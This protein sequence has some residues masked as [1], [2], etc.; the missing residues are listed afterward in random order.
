MSSSARFLAVPG[1]H[2][3]GTDP[4]RILIVD[5]SIVAR[6]VLSR[7]LEACPEFVIAAS[8][9]TAAQAL[10][11]VG[12][13]PVD[14]ILL[15]LEMPGVGGLEALPQLIARSDGARVLV[16]SSM[17]A[18]GAAA[19][20]QALALGAADTLQKPGVAN[21]DGRFSD[22]LADRLIRIAA[23]RRHRMKP[24]PVVTRPAG[25]ATRAPIDC[26]AIGASTGG[27][28][29]LTELLRDFPAAFT[30]PIL[31]TQHLPAAFMPYFADQMRGIA[32][33]P[34]TVAR[35]GEKLVPGHILIAPGEGHI[36][37]KRIGHD[38][39]VMLDTTVS[40]TLC[41][42]SVDPMF[43][44]LAEVYGERGLAVVLSG[45]GRDGTIGA[46]AVFGVGGEILVQDGPTSVVWGM[47]G[48]VAEAGL[49]SA[50]LPPA[51]I[52]DRILSRA[53]GARWS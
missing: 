31:I 33:R 21:F 39:R 43:E 22:T 49:A 10:D 2:P 14:I 24:A 29:A 9:A 16:V 42:P 28:H 4:I 17:A 23:G 1:S 38:V 46:K 36:R 37:L 20:V 26:L 48:S 32:G 13:E 50:V 27:L 44:S 25:M 45:M 15:D 18:D 7:I 6:T 3:A 30:A 34:A 12:R 8:V 52:A 41:M 47:P 53:G 40:A 51:R 35:D 11:L 19:T 5:D